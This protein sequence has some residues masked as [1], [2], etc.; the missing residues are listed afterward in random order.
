MRQL[1][2][3]HGIHEAGEFWVIMERLPGFSCVRSQKA[4][5]RQGRFVRLDCNASDQDV[6]EPMTMC[7]GL[8]STA[9]RMV[10]DMWS[11]SVLRT[12]GRSRLGVLKRGDKGHD[13]IPYLL[14]NQP[15][16]IIIGPIPSAA[17]PLRPSE[18]PLARVHFPPRPDPPGPAPPCSSGGAGVTTIVP[19]PCQP[20]LGR[21]TEAETD[22]G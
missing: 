5:L 9:F 16:C 17:N 18:Q 4:D 12:I 14:H 13:L 22:R 2:V 11:G 21:G 6:H 10:I 19:A 15:R 3:G 7:C 1:Y 8:T 20:A